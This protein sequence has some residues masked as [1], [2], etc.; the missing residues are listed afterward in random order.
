MM[1]SRAKPAIDPTATE[2]RTSGAALETIA[3]KLK[4]LKLTIR[5]APLAQEPASG[6]CL[7]TGQPAREQVLI[8]RAY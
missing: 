8:A 7:F 2:T 4:V 6:T 5:N 3:D 1:L